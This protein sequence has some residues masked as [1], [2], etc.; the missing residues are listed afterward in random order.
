MTSGCI[1]QSIDRV[2]TMKAK[3]NIIAALTTTL[4]IFATAPTAL[5]ESPYPDHAVRMIL[6][7]PPA[8]PVDI[9]GRIMA[10]RLSALWGQPVVV[11]NVSGAGG[12]IGGDRVAKSTPDGYTLLMTTNAQLV[13][14]PSLY[15][16]MPFDPAK[17]LMPISLSVYSP[18]ILV[19]P[20]DV[21][22]K[23]VA[24]LVA[25]A[26]ANPGKLSFASA[27]VGT[28]QHLA[29]ELFKNMAKIDIQHVPY[30]GA[31][32]VIPD[33]LGGRITMYFGAIAPLIPLVREG[34]LRALAV[35]S[36]TRFSAAPELPT[37]IEEGYPG[38]V[39]VLSMGLMAPAGTPPAI[40]AKIH[41]DAVIALAPPETRQRLKDIGMELIGSSP[42]EFAAS[43]KAETPQW[44][45]VIKD[46]GIAAS[47]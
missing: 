23:T 24:E 22:A 35:T 19:V 18:N 3:A 42:A 31:G 16:S 32:Q 29:G 21:P 41:Q 9:I 43:I 6:G 12:N 30:R 45:K 36:A 7:Y 40:I 39:S 4:S 13:V 8:G 27:G 20:N 17:D 38:F 10:D 33:L 25:Y 37:M 47:N 28:T 44:A 2:D 15:A 46:A 14:N 1:R 5:A 11:E 26:R 34:K